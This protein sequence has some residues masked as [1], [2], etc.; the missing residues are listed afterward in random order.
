MN[1][2]PNIFLIDVDGVLTTG[3]F[4]YSSQGKQYKVFGTDD[5][6][7]LS[8]LSKFINIK[9]I[10]GDIKGFDISKKRVSE[11]G[12]EIELVST[13]KRLEWINENYDFNKTIYMGDGIFDHYVF[14]SIF[15]SIAPQNAHKFAKK[16]ANFITE[17]KG[18]NGAIAEASIHIL[19]KFFEPFDPNKE[20]DSNIKYS[21]KWK[22]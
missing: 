19:E 18:G 12:Y 14:K 22:T 11:M 2:K 20:L 6:D 7:G 1:N 9:F 5:N 3:H 10:S 16:F 13:V 4:I 8:L 21:G 17:S 15:Y